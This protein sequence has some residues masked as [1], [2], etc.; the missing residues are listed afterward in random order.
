[1]VLLTATAVVA[2]AS[3]GRVDERLQ[4]GTTKL[5]GP[6]VRNAD[7]DAAD[8]GKTQFC[9]SP[10]QPGAGQGGGAGGGAQNCIGEHCLTC[11]GTGKC[12]ACAGEERSLAC[13]E[14]ECGA[15]ELVPLAGATCLKCSGDDC[16]ACPITK[17]PSCTPPT[18]AECTKVF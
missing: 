16:A 7:S 1:M 5:G 11:N 18:C 13:L 14:G 10:G 6:A 8:P 2:L 3:C 17:L 15:C 4:G 12:F 9:L